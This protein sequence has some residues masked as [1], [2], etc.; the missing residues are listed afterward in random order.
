[1]SQEDGDTSPK[2]VVEITNCAG[3]RR[4]IH[5]DELFGAHGLCSQCLETEGLGEHSGG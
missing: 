1:M 2:R 3:C 4:R 5:P